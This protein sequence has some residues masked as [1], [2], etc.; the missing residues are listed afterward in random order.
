MKRRS[1]SG[2]APRRAT[3]DVDRAHHALVLPV[4]ARHHA[5]AHPPDRLVGRASV[6]PAMPVRPI[7]VSAANRARA[8]S[9]SATATSSDTAPWRSIVSGGTPSSAD[10]AS[11]EYATTLPAK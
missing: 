1:S 2:R 9:A 8:P 6:G 5:E 4:A 7:A 11:F 3:R 10:L